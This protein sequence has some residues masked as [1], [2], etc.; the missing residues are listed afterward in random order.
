MNFIRQIPIVLALAACLC[1]FA[2]P[3]RVS[4]AE[5]RI[6][7]IID[8]DIAED[9][10]DILCTAFALN[11]PEFEVLAIT[12]VDGG[13]QARSRV[14]RKVAL[15]YGHPELPVAEGYVRSIPFE[16]T[17]Y[18]GFSGGVRYGE[19]APD[20]SGLPPG[21]LLKADE[22]IARLADKYP[23]EVT[24]VTIGSMSNVGQLLV[25]YPA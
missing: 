18:T 25:R 1:L 11:S 12:V 4:A 17:L 16:D 19:V 6:K 9:I 5:G 20:E 14:A 21:S 22:L 24:V 3:V 8:T 15:L 2:T 10:D 23:G 7:V 13:V